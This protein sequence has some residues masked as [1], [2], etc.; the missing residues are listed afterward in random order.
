M[1]RFT[2]IVM[3]DERLNVSLMIV[4]SELLLCK[5]LVIMKLK[6]LLDSSCFAV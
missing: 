4:D 5:D 6:L 1:Y 2:Y 3:G